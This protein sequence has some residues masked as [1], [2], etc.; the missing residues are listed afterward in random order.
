MKQEQ[1][2]RRE[3][4]RRNLRQLVGPPIAV[5]ELCPTYKSH[6]LLCCYYCIVLDGMEY[7]IFNRSFMLYKLIKTL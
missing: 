6:K 5:R 4:F 3:M 1:V 2:A 7:S